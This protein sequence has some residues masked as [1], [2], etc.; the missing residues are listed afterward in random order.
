MKDPVSGIAL[1]TGASSGIGAAF[2]RRL[3]AVA[4]GTERYRGL[5]AFD[6][7][8]L[9]ARRADRLADLSR[10]L[11]AVAPGLA[12]KTVAL[13]LTR[14]LA[15]LADRVAA[16]GKPLRLLVNNAG[17]GSY[18]PFAAVDLAKQLGEIDLNCRALTEACGRL[19]P[20]MASGSAVVNVASLAGF[21]PLGNFAVYAAT[22]AYALNF[23]VALATEWR[24]RGVRVVA[25]CPG[26]VASEFALV[27]SAGIRREVAHGWSADKTAA[28][29]LRRAGRG[30]WIVVPRLSWRLN[31]AATWLFGPILSAR[32]ARRFLSRPYAE[33]DRSAAPAAAD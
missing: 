16:A 32:F 19:G 24:E 12:V 27:A 20:F 3:A 18:G 23:S 17:Y 10:E 4:A 2:A 6:E 5:P 1:V 21:A 31:R 28:A 22:K 9:V 33:N 25:L 15:D 14:D 29:A 13:D 7:L 30:G 8:W 26:S 11:F